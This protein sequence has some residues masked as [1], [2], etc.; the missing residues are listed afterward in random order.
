M[1]FCPAFESFSKLNGGYYRWVWLFSSLSIPS[2]S[3][4]FSPIGT[5]GTTGFWALYP[6]GP[7]RRTKASWEGI[8]F[9]YYWATTGFLFYSYLNEKV[10]WLA[11]HFQVPLVFAAM[12]FF[13]QLGLD[14]LWE[15]KRWYRVMAAAGI[16]LLIFALRMDYRE[17][18][19]GSFP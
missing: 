10:P 17:T 16:C 1:G 14:R 11:L 8:S 3:R 9:F 12:G 13:D 6:I 18:F 5:D 19:T 15:N 2:C 4:R 7:L